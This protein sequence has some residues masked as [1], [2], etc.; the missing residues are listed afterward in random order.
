MSAHLC[1]LD[2][3]CILF[4]SASS[5]SLI[6]SLVRPDTTTH[7]TRIHWVCSRYAEMVKKNTI[8]EQ[9]CYNW[10]TLT[11]THNKK[12][13]GQINLF[14]FPTCCGPSGTP[15]GKTIN[16]SV[17]YWSYKAVISLNQ[18]TWYTPLKR[19]TLFNVDVFNPKW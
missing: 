3:C 5:S 8:N 14:H 11:L 15:S 6:V 19:K 4:V 7:K 12:H 16:F 17:I 10:L 18:Q 1:V 13:L 9:K 2:N